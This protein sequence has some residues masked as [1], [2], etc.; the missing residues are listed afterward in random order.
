MT[1]PTLAYTGKQFTGPVHQ[2]QRS[3]PPRSFH[4][5][6]RM[7]GDASS[8]A[9]AGNWSSRAEWDGLKGQC[10][11]QQNSFPSCPSCSEDE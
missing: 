5:P 9:A 3:D 10:R 7:A 8:S 4:R 6:N 1:L 11:G 2:S